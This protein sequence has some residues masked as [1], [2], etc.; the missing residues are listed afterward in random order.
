[1]YV[2]YIY[3]FY[4]YVIVQFKYIECCI[5]ESFRSFILKCSNKVTYVKGK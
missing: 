3:V 1:M 5:F 4:I 2:F